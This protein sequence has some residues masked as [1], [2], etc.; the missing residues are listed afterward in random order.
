MEK[1]IERLKNRRDV[2]LE[3]IYMLHQDIEKRRA[4][5]VKDEKKIDSLREE[6]ADIDQAVGV[7]E[8]SLAQ[9][10]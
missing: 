3:E 4:E 9:N 1:I 8:R 2:R 6:I 10:A 7:L 5:I